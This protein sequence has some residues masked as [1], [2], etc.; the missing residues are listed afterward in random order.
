MFWISKIG[1]IL[2]ILTFKQ[3]QNKI[4]LCFSSICTK[5]K[6]SVWRSCVAA[7]SSPIYLFIF[8]LMT[9]QQPS[10]PDW[11]SLSGVCWLIVYL[12]AVLLSSEWQRR[13]TWRSYA[14]SLTKTS[15]PCG[16]PS[17]Q[18]ALIGVVI[19]STSAP[20][21]WIIVTAKKIHLQSES[22]CNFRG[23]T[24]DFH[25]SFCRM[26]PNHLTN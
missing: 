9:Q 16:N 26:W 20:V 12:T 22:K 3:R 2:I 8:F 11:N 7:C 19:Y 1:R 23:F 24:L 17:A 6:C 18:S 21:T 14:H 4:H 25:N 13:K 5:K 10:W 15:R